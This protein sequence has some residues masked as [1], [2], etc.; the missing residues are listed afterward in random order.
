MLGV[1]VSLP[2]YMVGEISISS[3]SE[4]AIFA[5]ALTDRRERQG[6]TAKVNL[7]RLK[8]LSRA[9]FTKLINGR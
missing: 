8:E 9:G 4:S 5:L 1:I 6:V 2:C 7:S 3:R